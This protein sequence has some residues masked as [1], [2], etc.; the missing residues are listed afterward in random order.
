MSIDAVTLGGAV[1]QAFGSD[2]RSDG[3]AW[4]L[5]RLDFRAPGFT[6]VS[7]SGRL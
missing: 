1:L 7:V 5:D 3:A 4:R 2:L 6:K